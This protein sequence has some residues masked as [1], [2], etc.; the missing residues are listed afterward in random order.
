ME[1]FTDYIQYNK[2]NVSLQGNAKAFH[3]LWETKKPPETEGFLLFA[4]VGAGTSNREGEVVSF[5]LRR[6]RTGFRGRS[7]LKRKNLLPF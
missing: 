3:A 1:S 5:S 2:L 4:A 6:G 7:S